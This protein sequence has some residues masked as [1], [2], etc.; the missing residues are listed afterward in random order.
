[1]ASL[2][3]S[4]AAFANTASDLQKVRHMADLKVSGQDI[5]K[6]ISVYDNKEGNPCAD[7]GISYIVQVYVR[8]SVIKQNPDGGLGQTRE[9]QELNQYVI[10]KNDLQKGRDLSDARCME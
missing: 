7:E 10:S 8:K 5:K 3:L 1:M 2:V 4:S 9:W 6:E